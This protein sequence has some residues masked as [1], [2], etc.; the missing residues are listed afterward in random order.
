MGHLFTAIFFNLPFWFGLCSAADKQR[1]TTRR[2]RAN[3]SA[4]ILIFVTAQSNIMF[5][6]K[7][8]PT[9]ILTR[10]KKEEKCFSF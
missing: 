3:D 7:N 5:M 1:L 6:N 9:A 8:V 10:N 4:S 2:R